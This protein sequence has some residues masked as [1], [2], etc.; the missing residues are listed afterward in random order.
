MKYQHLTGAYA[1][2]AVID[3]INSHLFLLAGGI[4]F[5][6]KEY[7]VI[8]DRMNPGPLSTIG[9]RSQRQNHLVSRKNSYA[10]P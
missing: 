10:I 9:F 4:D 8:S 3:P 2:Q 7:L 1:P 6:D 5:F